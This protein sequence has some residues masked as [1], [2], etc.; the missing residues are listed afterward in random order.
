MKSLYNDTLE[1]RERLKRNI[2]YLGYITYKFMPIKFESPTVTVIYG[3][4]VVIQS[5]SK[6][7][8]AIMIESS[9]FA[10][11]QRR[12]FNELWKIARK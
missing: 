2:K 8:F 5:W 3:K 6:D 4:K 7:P 10:E 11:N 1:I 12:H 9:D